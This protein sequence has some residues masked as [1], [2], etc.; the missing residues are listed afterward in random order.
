MAKAV[1]P[2]RPGTNEIF[3]DFINRNRDCIENFISSDHEFVIKADGMVEMRAT[4]HLDIQ[5]FEMI[6]K[7]P[8]V[9]E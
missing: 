5:A 2:M 4:F 8:E 1:R 9:K 6:L 3:L 7:A